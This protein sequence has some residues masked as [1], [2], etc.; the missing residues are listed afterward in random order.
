MTRT[1]IAVAGLGGAFWTVKVITLTAGTDSLEA[2]L[3]VGGLV[4]LL[5]A[6]VLAARDLRRWWLAPAFVAG[7]IALEA[8]GVAVIGGLYSGANA[9]IED[10]GGILLAGLAWLALAT[11]AAK[12]SSEPNWSPAVS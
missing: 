3:F 7:T 5:V 4:L 2:P 9:A 10:E 8:L 1:T 12:R 11:W 6:A